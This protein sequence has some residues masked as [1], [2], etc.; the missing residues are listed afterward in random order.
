MLLDLAL[1]N[2]KDLLYNDSILKDMGDQEILK[3]AFEDGSSVICVRCNS[4][5]KRDR[6][7]AHNLKWCPLLQKNDNNDNN[8]DDDDDDIE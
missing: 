1:K 4:L 2:S 6:W 5:I 7:N 8:N 3:D